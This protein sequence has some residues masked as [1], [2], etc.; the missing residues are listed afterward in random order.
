MSTPKPVHECSYIIA[1]KWKQ[2]SSFVTEWLNKLR[3]IHT[4]KHYSAIERNKFLIQ[5]IWMNL[6][7]VM[8]SGE[9]ANTARLHAV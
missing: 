7:G 3:L 1:P 4:S 6:Q 5:A 9:G 8:L 2:H